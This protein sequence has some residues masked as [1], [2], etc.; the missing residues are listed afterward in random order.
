MSPSRRRWFKGVAAVLSV[1]FGMGILELCLRM[2]GVGYPTTFFVKTRHEGEDYWMENP[3][4][5]YRFMPKAQARS[6]RP[7]MVP[8]AKKT[9]TIRVFV[10]GESAA[11]GDPEPAFGMPE[12]LRVLL[13]SRYP[14]T[15][16]EVVNTALTAINSHL[17]HHIAAECVQKEADF[18]VLYM[19]NNE[20][21][22]PMGPGT[23][24]GD[25]HSDS[26]MLQ[27]GL[28]L[29]KYHLGQAMDGLRE[30]LSR[31][32]DGE[33]TKGWGGIAMFE[34][35]HVP[36]GDPRLLRVHAAFEH[37][38]KTI[39]DSAK[40]QGIPV[41]FSSLACNLKDSAPF[42][43]SSLSQLEEAQRQSWQDAYNQGVALLEAGL[44]ADALG[45]F[46]TAESIDANHADLQFSLGTSLL[47]LGE[48][49]EAQH[50][51]KH[52]RDMD[53]LR[54][55]PTDG[56]NDIIK[57]CFDENQSQG[58]YFFD[59]EKSME[60]MSEGGLPGDEFFWDHVHFKFQGNYLLARGFAEQIAAGLDESGS[61]SLLN[62]SEAD[63][64]GVETCA[65]KLGLTRWGQYQLVETML[66]RLNQFPFS[67]QSNRPVLNTKMLKEL[68]FLKLDV[69]PEV[70]KSMMDIYERVIEEA[71]YNWM[72]LDQ[73]ARF[74]KDY[75]ELSLAV[76][77]WKKILEIVP[78]HVMARFELGRLLSQDP[79]KMAEAEIYLREAIE[80]R[81]YIPEI[82][83][84]LGLCLGRQNKVE[85]A[86][87]AFRRATEI[88]PNAIQAHINWASALRLLGRSQEAIERLDKA[89]TIS[90]N[91][92]SA[93]LKMARFLTPGKD[94]AKVTFHLQEVIRL[95]PDHKEATDAL[96]KVQTLM[97]QEESN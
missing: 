72:A 51:F 36:M 4:F 13:E 23:V 31:K 49:A 63:W 32:F 43:S 61:L 18:L 89:L 46:Q 75:G 83:M 87:L 84:E 59:L 3:G 39:L 76:D 42:A 81:P 19:G 22:G 78:H 56:L 25:T 64:L 35:R 11:M 2:A 24:F 5:L 38:L 69:T 85:E 82:H 17:I 52:A 58:V 41:V 60:R 15:R 88:Q 77:Q 54:F 53:L 97:L 90:T 26:W 27:L 94:W 50:Y 47:A 74:L 93:H 29:K 71:S 20:V 66:N 16:F 37:H 40:K 62:A 57:Q 55:R 45:S 68:E 67:R 65:A 14:Q 80:L 7:V 34:G 92:V 10:L 6:P 28:Q 8:V 70:L 30:K 79:E 86:L 48:T 33:S 95:D 1:V 91:S 96:S 44:P 12:I 73:Y 9:N 21:T